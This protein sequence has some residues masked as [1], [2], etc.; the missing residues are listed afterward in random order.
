MRGDHEVNEI[1]LAE[2][3][4]R[5]AR[6]ALADDAAV[7]RATGAPVGFAGPVGLG[8][9]VPLLADLGTRGLRSF[10]AGA[11][12]ADA[13]Y[14]GVVLGPR[15]RALA[16]APTCAL[17]RG[18]DPCP[19]CGTPLEESAASRSAHIFKLGTKYSEAM[20]CHLHRR[21]RAP[22]IR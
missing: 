20:N 21:G 4:R 7:A 6:C 5:R 9:G 1:K 18:G 16:R 10:G 12:Q 3:P 19:R 11:N 13:H 17:V 22:T 2:R 14:V 15:R 8:A